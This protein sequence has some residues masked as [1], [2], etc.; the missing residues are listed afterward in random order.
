M[1]TILHTIFCRPFINLWSC[2]KSNIREPLENNRP[3][4]TNFIK[5]TLN[6][7]ENALENHL[8]NADGQGGVKCD[9]NK[10]LFID[11]NFEVQVATINGVQ[12]VLGA[13]VGCIGV[14]SGSAKSKRNKSLQNTNVI[15]FNIPL[16]LHCWKS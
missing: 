10:V 16:K 3:S 13:E 2:P 8:I 5:S 9:E 12:I 15:K 6:D 14:A 1:K 4:L 7:I 11:V